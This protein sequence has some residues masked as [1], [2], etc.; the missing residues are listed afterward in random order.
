MVKLMAPINQSLLDEAVAQWFRKVYAKR[1]DE[2]DELW[3]IA[4]V[5]RFATANKKPLE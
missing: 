1:F 5:E 3:K 2:L 4:L